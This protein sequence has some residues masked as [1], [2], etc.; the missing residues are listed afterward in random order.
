[1][2]ANALKL[3]RRSFTAVALTAAAFASQAQA[4]ME[5]TIPVALDYTGPLANSIE[6]WW[7]G[8]Q[9]VF[10]WW[11]ETKGRKLGVKLVP[12]IYDMRYDAAVVARTWPQILNADKPILY[13][14]VGTPDMV[15]LSKR[16]PTDKVPMVLGGAMTSPM[17]TPDGWHF[18]VRP[19]YSHEHAGLFAYLQSKLPQKRPLRIATLGSQGNVGFVDPVNGI[20]ALAKTYPEKF[21]VV[22]SQWVDVTPVS[23]SNQVAEMAKTQPDI[24][25]VNSSMQHA[26]TTLKALK[27][28]GLKIPISTTSHNGLSEL[29]T[30]LPIG[31]LEG[32]YSVFAFAP[33]ND[34]SVKAADIFKKYNKSKGR[35]GLTAAQTTAQAMFG[36]AAIER[37]IAKVGP[38]N[39]TGQAV[40]DAI[41]TGSYAADQ[42]EGLLPTLTF[43]KDAPFPTQNLAVKAMTV[44]DGKLV[45]VSSDWMPVPNLSKW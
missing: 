21:T 20:I 16:L 40:Y 30:V 37:A 14:A 6:S 36:V 19:T 17:W 5:Y 26:V 44:K 10:D 22:S 4:L 33:Y 43:T 12:K 23:V 31:D 7:G 39:L 42:F 45:S 38:A 24:I 35:W 9:S 18:S 1:M 34:S 8:Q 13:L 27:D 15:A 29:A 41:V 3:T 2:H 25:M 28:L 11:N 32:S